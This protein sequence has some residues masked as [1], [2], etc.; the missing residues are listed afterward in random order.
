MARTPIAH[1]PG[2]GTIGEEGLARWLGY[3]VFFEDAQT[4][5]L[6]VGI[7]SA[8]SGLMPAILNCRVLLRVWP[9]CWDV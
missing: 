4:V 1:Q 3:L 9:T 2:C 5:T 6:I 7:R 8:T